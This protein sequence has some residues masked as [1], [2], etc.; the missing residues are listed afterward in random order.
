VFLAQFKFAP[1]KYDEE[2]HTLDKAIGEYAESLPGYVGVERWISPDGLKRNSMYYFKD[3]ETI[4]TFAKFPE[5]LDAKKQYAKWYDG[6]E[7]VISEIKA[8]YGDGKIA[9]VLNEKRPDH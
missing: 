2:F 4:Q 9:S 3:M 5:H 8:S 7:V 6:Y 1:G